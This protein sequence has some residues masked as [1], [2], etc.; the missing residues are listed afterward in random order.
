M[1]ILK[2]RQKGLYV[3][4]PGTLPARTPVEI[5][6]TNCNIS[7]VD[8]YLRKNGI[9][10]YEIY[11][12][13]EKQIQHKKIKKEDSSIN[14]KTFNN[15]FSRL[16]KMLMQLLEK[17][18]KVV[19]EVIK[20]KVRRFEEEPNIEELDE[21]FIPEIDTSNMKMK[22]NSKQAVKQDKNDL[23]DSAELLSRIMSQDD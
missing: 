15:R 6:I 21:I 10:N 17:E 16:E 14:Q 3:E 4:L 23:D 22:G 13:T 8:T 20:T 9:N 12:T 5:N 7:I 2:I 19:K 1:L 11:S 18:P